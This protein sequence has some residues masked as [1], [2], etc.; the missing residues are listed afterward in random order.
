MDTL[1]EIITLKKIAVLSKHRKQVLEIKNDK[2]LKKIAGIF[3]DSVEQLSQ[4]PP[5]SPK[6]LPEHFLCPLFKIKN[7]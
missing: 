7:L 4:G 5:S 2:E 6:A 1:K 3:S